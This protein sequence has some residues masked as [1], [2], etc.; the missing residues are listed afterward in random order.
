VDTV[1]ERLAA[2]D[3]LAVRAHVTCAA[4][5]IGVPELVLVPGLGVSHRYLLPF[6]RSIGTAH[7]CYALD[8]PGFGM[9]TKPDHML[10][11]ADYAE[12]VAMWMDRTGLRRAVL[13]GNSLGCGVVVHLAAHYPERVAG[14]ILTSPSLDPAGRTLARTVG[15]WL[16][17]VPREPMSMAPIIARDWLRTGP[18]W[19]LRGLAAMLADPIE[20]LLPRVTAPTLVVRGERDAIVPRDWA[21]EAAR[22]LPYGRL[23]EIPGAVHAVTFDA[24]ETLA[25]LVSAFLAEKLQPASGVSRGTA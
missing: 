10:S 23:V 25:A 2:V 24:P 20:E 11:V 8:L 6:A 7:R 3:R 18:V 19:M 13:M 5:C 16:R 17:D 12:L 15:R 9:W 1:E 22:L 14:A 4:Q 21:Q